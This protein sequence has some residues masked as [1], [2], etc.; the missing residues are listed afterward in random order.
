MQ[1]PRFFLR[2]RLVEVREEER[3]GWVL[4]AGGIIGHDVDVTWEVGSLMAVA[5]SALVE[6]CHVAYGC[7]W[8]F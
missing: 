6:A 1:H 3:I 7:R 5:M 8:S 2:I 4:Q